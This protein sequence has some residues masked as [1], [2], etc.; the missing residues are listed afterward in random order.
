LNVIIER[1]EIYAQIT[2]R[3]S[4]VP[5]TEGDVGGGVGLRYYF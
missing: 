2:P 4:V 5:D 3:I 1:F